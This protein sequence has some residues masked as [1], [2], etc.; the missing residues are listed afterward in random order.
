MR[1]T[2]RT[3]L[4][5]LDHTLEPA[6]EA[7]L[8]DKVQQSGFASDLVRRIHDALSNAQLTAPSPD[9]AGPI[10]D[11]NT[12]AE[13]LDNTLAPEATAEVE[14]QCIESD[15]HLAEVAANHQVLTLALG[16]PAH[17]PKTLRQRVYAQGAN[18][19]TSDAA[20]HAE[21]ETIAAPPAM[22]IAPVGPS[23][24]GVA[25]ATTRLPQD[26][27][28]PAA[29]GARE[30]AAKQ[31]RTESHPSDAPAAIAGERARETLEAMGVLLSGGR[32]SRVTPWL[33]SLALAAVFLFVLTQAF[34]PFLRRQRTASPDHQRIAESDRSAGTA[35][36]DSAARDSAPREDRAEERTERAGGGAAAEVSDG[37]AS[38]ANGANGSASAA[39]DRDPERASERPG[40]SRPQSPTANNSGADGANATEPPPPPLPETSLP[41]DASEPPLE[42]E[43][44]IERDP[45]EPDAADM[46]DAAVMAS[47]ESRDAVEAGQGDQSSE[48]EQ[49]PSMGR[50]DNDGGLLLTQDPESGAWDRIFSDSEIESGVIL[51]CGPTFRSRLVLDTGAELT[52]IGPTGLRIDTVGATGTPRLSID[53]GRVLIMS[54]AAEAIAMSIATPAAT[55]LVRLGEGGTTAAVSV[56]HHRSPGA[57]PAVPGNSRPVLRLLSVQNKVEW[58]PPREVDSVS[59]NTGERLQIVAGGEPTIAVPPTIPGWLDSPAEAVSSLEA[60]ARAGLV[61]LL[62]TGVPLELAL[63]EAVNFRREEVGALAARTLLTIGMPDSYFGP[64]GVL[65]RPGQ[66]TYWPELVESLRQFIDRG[67]HA[68]ALVAQ[69]AYQLE[70][71]AAEKMLRLLQGFSEA[72]LERGGDATLVAMLDSQVMAVRVLAAETLRQITGTSLYFRA[73]HETAARRSTGVKKWEARLKR[74]QIRWSEPV[75]SVE[76]DTP[77][78]NPGESPREP[79]AERNAGETRLE[80]AAAEDTEEDQQE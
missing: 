32:P 39:G 44:V 15:I 42:Y 49:T 8:G 3:L 46:L 80:E 71:E 61:G 74:G 33:V 28:I 35:P 53:F 57:D 43:D 10:D 72:Q 59:L 75:T 45:A 40:Q 19:D 29:S 69:A 79:D 17:V 18:R 12:I 77:G 38:T 4:A 60:T 52:L 21:N 16:E 65:N 30:T 63:R 1:L 5:Y 37:S 66:R 48:P 68:A 64:D 55:G 73:D 22:P 13:Y 34:Q 56:D 23:D 14:R 78:E 26:A 2:L 9:A 54:T 67:P 76:D 6:D 20:S 58:Q 27:D 24:T 41:A 47:E 7:A 70:G 50:V 25:D 62:S 51:V 36:Q 31:T 11:A